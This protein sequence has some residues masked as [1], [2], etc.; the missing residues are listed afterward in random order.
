MRRVKVGFTLVELLVV[1]A[2][3]GVLVGLLLPAVQAARE[4]ARRMQCANNEKQIGLAVLNYD[5]A[6]RRFPLTVTGNGTTNAPRGSG[7]YSWLAMILPQMDQNPLYEQID[8][9]VSMND[10]YQGALPDY[11]KVLISSANANA[12]AASTFVPTYL[13][14]SD[15]VNASE[16]M[17]SAI[18][19]PG[20]YAGNIGWVRR[21]TGSNGTS[22]ELTKANGAMPIANPRA[23]DG[24]F[25]PLISLANFSDGTSSTALAS[26]RVIN[27]STVSQGPFSAVMSKGPISTRSFCAGGVTSRTLANWVNYCKG[28]STPDPTYS[29]PHGRAWISGHTLA[30][31]LYMHVMPPNSRNCHIYGGEDD[32]N[33]IVSA[34]SKHTSG[35]NVVFADGH[36]EF[37]SFSVAQE[38]WWAIGSRNGAETISLEN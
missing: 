1:I 30:A 33:N 10:A 22:P 12:R 27:A 36:V 25:V 4:A 18:P 35:L 7:F 28:V 29:I 19:A 24:W 17:G 9:R 32:G 31:N 5:S 2:I 6:H 37:V 16:N 23:T 26:E 14:P 34:S 3:I 20:S 21:T 8:F 11:K 15:P 38:V 13:C